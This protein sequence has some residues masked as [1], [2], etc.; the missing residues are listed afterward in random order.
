MTNDQFAASL[1][2]LNAA[3]RTAVEATEGPVM[4]IAGPGTGKTH[5]L[6]SRVGKILLDTDTKPGSILCLTFT[7][8]GVNAMRDRLLKMIG[9]DAYKVA[10]STFHGFC[11]RVIQENIEYFGYGELEPVSD[12]ERIEIIRGLIDALPATHPLRDGKR[13]AYQYES[14]LRDLFT[15]MKKEN[16]S[17]AHIAEMANSYLSGLPEDPA[18]RYQRNGA[19]FKKGDLK[20][21]LINDVTEKMS[22]LVSAAELYSAYVDA[23]REAKRYEFEDMILWVLNAFKTD[24]GFLRNYQERY[25]Y[26]QVD[27]FQDTNG[28]QYALLKQLLD[29]WESPNVFIVGDDDQSIYEFQGARLANLSDFAERMEGLEMVV[30]T[31]NYRSPKSVLTSASNLISRNG[32]RAVNRFEVEKNLRANVK[33]HPARITS[34]QNRFTEVVETT[35]KIKVLLE[36]GV[37]PKEIAVIY[38][39]HRQA[40]PYMESLAKNGIKFHVKRPSNLLDAP[41]IQQLRELLTYLLEE[42]ERPYS[43]DHRLFR[44]LHCR[45]FDIDPR[46]LAKISIQRDKK[47]IIDCISDSQWLVGV[48]LFSPGEIL[49]AARNIKDWVSWVSNAPLPAM[50]ENLYR[51]SGMLTLALQHNDH[52]GKIN[53]LVSFL[54]FVKAETAKRPRF[55]GP[56]KGLS[57]LLGLLDMMDANGISMPTINRID[58]GEG[59]QLMTAHAAKGLEF[60]HVFIIDCVEDAWEKNPGNS[61]GRF[62]LPPTLVPTGEEDALESRRRLFYVAMTRAKRCLEI[63]YARNTDDGKP[64]AHSMFVAETGIEI[65]DHISDV[66]KMVAA[67]TLLLKV[68]NIQPLMPE[69]EI[70]DNALANYRMSITGLNRYLKCPIS[71]WYEDIIRVPYQPSEAAMYGT[72]LHAVLQ[73]FTLDMKAHGRWPSRLMLLKTFDIELEKV[74]GSMTDVAYKQRAALGEAALSALHEQARFWPTRSL[75]EKRFSQVEVDGVPITG[76]IDKIEWL[77]NGSLRVVDYKTGSADRIRIAPPSDKQPLGGEYWRQMVFYRLLVEGSGLYMEPVSESA[78]QYVDAEPALV[79]IEHT[80][81]DVR[82]MRSLIVETWSNIQAKKFEGCGKSDCQWCKMHR[83]MEGPIEEIDRPEEGLDDK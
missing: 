74:S 10:I 14:S 55:F 24:E 15:T 75:A 40:E 51:Q 37:D 22:R 16:W 72:S 46:D 32:I 79:T 19:T 1:K 41:L 43:G 48:A 78:I 3:Q 39:K 11:N 45:F 21:G 52:I 35:D 30:L 59:V 77:Q 9:P 76:V 25:L 82:N 71:F 64:L 65:N 13:N 68:Q 26:V 62:A 20:T 5:I 54:E 17:P 7:D 80:G 12:L 8:A 83:W 2:R 50:I 44:L 56:G 34:Y 70:V 31:E 63:S 47:P 6:A 49:S 38:S 33:D 58:A 60:E 69:A 27:E 23:M 18:F 61:R 73:R 42:S 53:E 29:Y 28:A 66:G 4:V 81:E 67:Q 57:R 36:C